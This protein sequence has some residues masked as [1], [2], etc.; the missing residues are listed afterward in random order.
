MKGY[1]LRT[2][3]RTGHAVDKGISGTYNVIPTVG[4]EF[5]LTR[6]C[7]CVVHIS[8]YIRRGNR[9]WMPLRYMQFNILTNI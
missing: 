3:G 4:Q 9:E 5:K 2:I 8:R 6:W 1:L 7:Y